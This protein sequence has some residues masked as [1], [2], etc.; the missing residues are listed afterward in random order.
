MRME[1][2]I[3]D[4]PGPLLTAAGDGTT[5]K[6][7]RREWTGLAVLALACLVYS[8]D[9][10]VLHLA[11]PEISEVLRPTSSQLL[12][13]IDVYGFMVAGLLLTMGTIGDRI[14]R[15]RL[16]M[17][18]AA[19]FAAV[20]IIAAFAPSAPVLIGCRA[21]LGVAGA[22][23]APSTLSLIFTMFPDT[24]QRSLAVGVW[25]G[26]YSVGGSI[27]PLAGGL[28]LEHFWWGSVFLLAVP[29]M[30]LLLILAPRV[31]PEFRDPDAGR[32]D[33]LSALMCTSAVLLV[34]YGMKEIAQDGPVPMAIG[35]LAAG[36]TIGS[37]FIRR[38]LT[39]PE[40]ML[41]L[42]LFRLSSFRMALTVN[43][44]AIF[45]AFG[46][47]LFVGQYFQ[48][49][50]GMSPLRA[51]I[52]TIP[53][54]LGFMIGSQL[55]PRIGKVV[56]PA[57]MIGVGMVMAAGGLLLLTRITETGGVGL[58]IIASLLVSFGLAPVFG[59]TTELIVGTAPPEQAGAASGLSETGAEFGGALGISML[60]SLSI[61]IYRSQ[62]GN[63]LPAGLRDADVHSARDT[64]GAAMEVANGLPGKLGTAV[65]ESAKHAFLTGMHLTS[66]I[67]A[68]AALLLAVIAV[69]RL[70]HIPPG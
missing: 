15:R 36:L 21:L 54:G 62:L 14:G 37:T 34:V 67:A 42:K 24:R 60:G 58:T 68:V 44:V 49:V 29:V 12:W 6:V 55:G 18:G 1:D 56:R 65:A 30:V 10:T 2:V 26:S 46:Y 47:F 39:H 51:G 33:L 23:L 27:G 25:V 31:L 50:L 41:D 69:L 66:A 32:L 4:I 48:L 64:L 5:T 70:R 8:M 11:V 3:V 38:Q 7:G 20:S 22:T 13:I 35:A 45:A 52:A 40:P 63:T 61:A 17:T 28:M 43:M 53:A 16:L 59:I 19:A 57:Y 9:L